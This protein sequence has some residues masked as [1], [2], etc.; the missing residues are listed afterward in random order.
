MPT[1]EFWSKP[2]R[3]AAP[4][5]WQNHIMLLKEKKKKMNQIGSP[6][7]GNMAKLYPMANPVRISD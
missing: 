2:L 7:E 1:G 3:L 6:S 5:T 4:N